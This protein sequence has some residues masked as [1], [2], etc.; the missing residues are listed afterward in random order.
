MRSTNFLIK[1]VLGA[2][3]FFSFVG[4]AA[5]DPTT[6]TADRPDSWLVLYNLSDPDSI[7]WAQWF[8]QE[9]GIP[10][11]NMLGL[12]TSTSEGL[13]DGAAAET[14]IYGPVRQYLSA[15]PQVGERVMGIIAGYR[16]P[17]HYRLR[18]GLPVPG[19]GPGGFAIA[20]GLEDL[21]NELKEVNPHVPPHPGTALP[22]A[23]LT[24]ASMPAGHYIV[25]RIDAGTLDATRQITLRAQRVVRDGYFL[26]WHRA[27]YDY[28]DPDLPVACRCW[29][30]LMQTVNSSEFPEI[31]WVEFDDDTEQTPN[32]V[33]RFGTYDVTGWANFRLRGTPE[34]PRVL[35]YNLNS[36]GAT[37]VRS[38]MDGQRY[39]PNA[40]DAGFAAAIGATGEPASVIGP[41]PDTLLA[42][43]REGW[44]LGESFYVSNP[45]NDWVWI[46]VGD[47][48][49]YIQNWF[50]A[51]LPGDLDADGD[52]DLTDFARF[53]NCF[54]GSDVPAETGCAVADLD[55][56]GDVDLLDFTVFQRHFTGAL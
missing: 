3:V 11:E 9:R 24:R 7:T 10:A 27:Y 32:D 42:G 41:F 39:V 48:F 46:L 47:P 56:D 15:N 45:Y 26:P 37:T 13:P 44:T 18:N 20:S 25:V 6:Q 5:A 2:A 52:V 4:V 28:S 38:I 16:I 34:G 21:N 54:T 33:V 40:I 8:Q 49:L 53:S 22:G 12:V 1:G 17:G 31:P 51:L 35:A 30:W 50:G 29:Y 14:Q 23:R 55:Q 36:W 19:G 43:L